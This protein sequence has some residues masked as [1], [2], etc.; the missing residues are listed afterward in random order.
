MA[1]GQFSQCALLWPLDTPLRQRRWGATANVWPAVAAEFCESSTAH[2]GDRARMAAGRGV[3]PA[4]HTRTRAQALDSD[5]EGEQG[6]VAIHDCLHALL[7]PLGNGE[8]APTARQLPPCL[9]QLCDVHLRAG[10]G[11]TWQTGTSAASPPCG[12]R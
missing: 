3:P 12:L 6:G 5:M 8:C 4:P 1:V 11:G 7:P 10:R 9:T 2:G